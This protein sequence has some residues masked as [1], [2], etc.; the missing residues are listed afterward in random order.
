ME[1][2]FA[3]W[4]CAISPPGI[5]DSPQAQLVDD[6]VNVIKNLLVEKNVSFVALC[7]VNEESF[8][9]LNEGLSDE[10]F[11]SVLLN[12][13]TKTGSRFDICLFYSVQDVSISEGVSHTG[14]VGTSSIKI[15]QQLEVEVKNNKTKVN[16]LISHWPSRLQYVSDSFRNECSIGLR[17]FVYGLINDDLQVILMGDYNDD[18]YSAGLFKNLKATNDRA[19]V[20]SSTKGWLYNPFWRELIA[21]EYFSQDSKDHDFGTCYSKANNRNR[22]STFD[23]IIFSGNFLQGGPWF[24]KESKT[25]VVTDSSLIN[26]VMSDKHKF[27]HLPVF[28]CIEY[29][30]EKNV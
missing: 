5:S 3:F 2:S 16:F 4:N 24:L 12:D 23:Q 11:Q 21:R 14:M 29:L 30:E 10:R 17:N 18:P 1:I 15:A 19:L 7:E 9:L 25:G 6:A 8:A 22:W 27:D 26:M 28:G 20:L 13:K